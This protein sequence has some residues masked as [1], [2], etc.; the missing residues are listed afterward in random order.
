MGIAE[1]LTI[2]FVVCKIGSIGTIATWS[3]FQVFLPMIIV[4]GIF[5]GGVLITLIVGTI[6]A[7]FN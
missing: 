4:Y 2:I 3:W 1:I 7:I 5:I 6:I